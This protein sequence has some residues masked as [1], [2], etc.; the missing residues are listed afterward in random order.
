[1]NYTFGIES[2]RTEEQY[3]IFKFSSCGSSPFRATFFRMERKILA[4]SPPRGALLQNR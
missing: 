2:Q 4:P 1:M 3:F